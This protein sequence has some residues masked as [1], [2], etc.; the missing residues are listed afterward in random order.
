MSGDVPCGRADHLV[1]I[2]W[3]LESCFLDSNP[4]TMTSNSGALVCNRSSLCLSFLTFKLG[5]LVLTL[6][7]F[8]EVK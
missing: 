1:V 3:T 5:M 2:R 6:Q 4:S 7:C 8:V